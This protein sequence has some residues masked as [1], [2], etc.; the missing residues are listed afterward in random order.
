MQVP[1][2]T[3]FGTCP[4]ERLK[5][6]SRCRLA[7]CCKKTSSTFFRG[8]KIPRKTRCQ[9]CKGFEK[10]AG[11]RSS[12]P[13]K[14]T[15]LVSGVVRVDAKRCILPQRKHS[16]MTQVADVRVAGFARIQ[17]GWDRSPSFCESIGTSTNVSANHPTPTD[18]G[19][20]G[21]VA[22]RSAFVQDPDSETSDGCG[23]CPT[24]SG[25]SRSSR[26]WEP[27]SP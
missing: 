17:A 9:G 3:R 23:R 13:H 11:E 8:Q 7:A 18:H 21:P 14:E 10:L 5:S 12:K 4:K 19:R 15:A 20:R 1:C 22:G 27:D 16:R 2:Q 26:G 25:R 6:V 24:G